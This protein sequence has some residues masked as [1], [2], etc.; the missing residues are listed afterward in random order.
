MRKLLASIALLLAPAVVVAA[1]GGADGPPPAHTNISDQGSLQRGAR[2]FVNY[3]LSC[4]S[5]KYMRYSRMAEDLGLTEDEVMA[6]LN[7]TGAKFGEPML[8]AMTPEDAATWFGAAPPDLS[9]T[10][11]SR[12]T[13]W[14]ADYLKSFYADPTRPTGWNNTRLPNASMPNVLW[15][16]QGVQRAVLESDGHGGTKV[17]R[18][19]LDEAHKGTMS[20]EQYDEAVRDLT[21]FLEYIAEPA[22]LE[23]EAYGVWV[24]LFLAFF[25]LIAYLLKLEWWKD[26]H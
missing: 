15:E 22:A 26:V 20:R 12:G 18:L 6:N 19:E 21:T 4:H 11:R 9:L 16:L 5:A 3:C 24:V 13:A 17:A 7:F 1:G 10:A 25:T 2:L 8:V 14:I 23:R